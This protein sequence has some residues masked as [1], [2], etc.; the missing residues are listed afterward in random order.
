M[1]NLSA[2]VG[3][4]IFAYWPEDERPHHPGPKF[5]PVLVVDVSDQR[6]LVAYGTSQRT[7]R[8]A[9]GEI[10]VSREDMPG[11][12]KDTKFCLGKTQWIPLSTE[13]IEKDGRTV[14]LGQ[15]PKHLK[16][17]FMSRIEEMGW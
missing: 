1:A 7:D 11:L 13:Y 16:A 17:D 6:A 5:R 9:R 2:L 4:V 8:N 14:V 12:S 3:A 15:I 10:T